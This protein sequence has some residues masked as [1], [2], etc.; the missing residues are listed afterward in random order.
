MVSFRFT[1]IGFFTAAVGLIISG[2]R[3]QEAGFALVG[4]SVA[5]WLIEVRNRILLWRYAH[6]GMDIEEHWGYRQPSALE[7]KEREASQASTAQYPNLPNPPLFHAPRFHGCTEIRIF[8]FPIK[9][10]VDDNV[11]VRDLFRRKHRNLWIGRIATHSVG[12]DL[13]FL[14]TAIYGVVLCFQGSLAK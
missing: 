8:F 13:V 12:I 4:L 6:R 11:K 14:M 9:I 10:E 3:T 5:I 2:G 1:L 7:S